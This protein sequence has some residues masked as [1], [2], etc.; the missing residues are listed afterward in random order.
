MQGVQ[1][2]GWHRVSAI[3]VS[4]V[5]ITD[6]EKQTLSEC[7]FW[8]LN[9]IF[10]K[11]KLPLA[12]EYWVCLNFMLQ[13]FG[14]DGVSVC[15]YVCVC[16][17][18][19]VLFHK[20]AGVSLLQG[21]ISGTSPLPAGQNATPMTHSPRSTSRAPGPHW[22]CSAHTSPA[23]GTSYGSL[24]TIAP[25]APPHGAGCPVPSA[26]LRSATEVPGEVTCQDTVWATQLCA[27]GAV[28]APCPH[29]V[30]TAVCL[31]HCE[32]SLPTQGPGTAPPR[33]SRDLR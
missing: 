20:W 22:P 18:L 29:R 1:N 14:T 3:Q 15:P 2:R 6:N 13:N 7:Y 32:P 12:L 17:C 9:G 10:K 16:T 21:D 31:P 27:A 26:P 28:P 19:H 23:P 11:Y 25:A 5:S 8:E 4:A 33:S 24:W 30:V